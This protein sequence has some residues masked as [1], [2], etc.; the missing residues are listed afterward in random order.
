M[1]LIDEQ[2]VRPAIEA[3]ETGTAAFVGRTESGPE[4]VSP[5][6]L[7]SF[8]QYASLYGAGAGLLAQSVHG[9]FAQGG[10]RLFIANGDD[11]AALLEELEAVDGIS[12][13]AAPG[14]ADA[15]SALIGHVEKTRFRFALLDSVEGMGLG[16][17]ISLRRAIDSRHAALY[18]PWVRT[19]GIEPGTWALTPP[20]GLAAGVCARV[21]RDRGVWRAPAGVSLELALGT[22]RPI[23]QA[24]NERL[25]HEGI[26]CLR[27]F[28]GRGVMLWGARTT[29]QDP[30][31]RYVSTRR[32]V[33]FIAESLTRGLGWTVFE[34]TGEPL[35]AQVRGVVEAFLLSLWRNGALAGMRPEHA[36]FVHCGRNTMTQNDIDSGRLIVQIGIAPARPGEFVIVRVATRTAEA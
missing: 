10:R 18:Y 5:E 7:G 2:P 34:T 27:S 32:V 29:S 16:E 4:G 35:W 33:N 19:S 26:N 15:H 23:G 8:S 25:A 6:P 17:V 9:Y 28:P 21:D 3:A 22:E 36:F 24:E 12:L 31:F 1:E 20:S 11:A 30:E 13:V 14:I